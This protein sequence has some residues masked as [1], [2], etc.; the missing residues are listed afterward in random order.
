M[1][2]AAS[3][4]LLRRTLKS[5]RF[6]TAG[7]SRAF[8]FSRKKLSI[9]RAS[10]PRIA[11]GPVSSRFR[12]PRDTQIDWRP[13]NFD[14]LDSRDRTILA[15]PAAFFDSVYS[16]SCYSSVL[17]SVDQRDTRWILA[18]A[19]HE[20]LW[21]GAAREEPYRVR[22]ERRERH[23]RGYLPIAVRIRERASEATPCGRREGGART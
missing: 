8:S 20:H 16:S 5:P 6:K 21:R 12:F 15:R 13:V 14:S 9:D 11:S 7:D 22:E 2:V 19:R 10:E 4:I 18:R 3:V 23:G 17:L 1:H